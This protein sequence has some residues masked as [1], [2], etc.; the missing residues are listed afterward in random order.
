MHFTKI[1]FTDPSEGNR[2]A[3]VAEECLFINVNDV[4]EKREFNFRSGQ[5]ICCGLLQL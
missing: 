5:A 1:S 2:N 4:A 3:D